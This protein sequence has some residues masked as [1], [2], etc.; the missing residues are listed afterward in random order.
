MTWGHSRAEGNRTQNWIDE[1][2]EVTKL[3]SGRIQIWIPFHFWS[4]LVSTTRCLFNATTSPFFR[5]YLEMSMF[6]FWWVSGQKKSDPRTQP[7]FYFS[8]K[9]RAPS[10]GHTLP[11]I[12]SKNVEGKEIVFLH[13]FYM[14]LHQVGASALTLLGKKN[15]SPG[16]SLVI[17]WLRL[18]TSTAGGTGLIP[19]RGTKISHASWYDQKKQTK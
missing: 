10:S 18:R 3:V 19:G 7:I 9:A 1:L 2:P 11:P 17:Q 5:F 8:I 15:R 12:Q 14:S 16:T 13:W 4:V 6:C